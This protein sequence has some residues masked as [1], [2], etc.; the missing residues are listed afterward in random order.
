MYE[1]K[2]NLKQSKK[3]I[4]FIGFHIPIFFRDVAFEMHFLLAKLDGVSKMIGGGV[5]F[6]N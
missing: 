4:K 5:Y 3:Q 2:G 6:R 1:H